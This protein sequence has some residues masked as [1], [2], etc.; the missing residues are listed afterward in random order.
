[1]DIKRLDYLSN[2]IHRKICRFGRYDNENIDYIFKEMK[3]IMKKGIRSLKE[4]RENKLMLH[5]Q[6]VSLSFV[7]NLNEKHIDYD[8][9][10]PSKNTNLQRKFV[11]ELYQSRELIMSILLRRF[12]PHISVIQRI[13]KYN[14][15]G[16]DIYD[17][18]DGKQRLNAM[19]SFFNNEF[20]LLLDGEE[21]YFNEL[22]EDYKSV[23]GGHHIMAFIIY[24]EP[25]IDITDQEK[26]DW[27]RMI[28][29]GGTAQDLNHLEKLK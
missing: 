27:F 13:N 29:F 3:T 19:Q 24:D 26:I 28:N 22:P 17:I 8:V 16:G 10:L 23:I 4:L 15:N 5:K 7:R 12:I 20:T 25:N 18:I 6:E 21:F 14:I 11:W 2:N 1:M 9:W